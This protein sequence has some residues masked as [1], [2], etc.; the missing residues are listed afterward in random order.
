MRAGATTASRQDAR[1][2]GVRA[3]SIRSP[4]LARGQAA[5]K[6]SSL[7]CSNQ[8]TG[9]KKGAAPST[10]LGQ[11][12]ALSAA[13]VKRELGGRGAQPLAQLVRIRIQGLQGAARVEAESAE[14]VGCRSPPAAAAHPRLAQ[15]TSGRCARG[16]SGVPPKGASAAA[17]TCAW[18]RTALAG[19]RSSRRCNPLEYERIAAAPTCSASV[20][21]ARSYGCDPNRSGC[22]CR[23]AQ[24]RGK[25][26]THVSARAAGAGRRPGNC[27][28]AA[29]AGGMEGGCR[30]W[31]CRT[32]ALAGSAH[33]AHDGADQP[34]LRGRIH[35]APAAVPP[36]VDR[37][38]RASVAP[39]AA[40]ALEAPATLPSGSGGSRWR[41]LFLLA[42]PRAAWLLRRACAVP[43]PCL[44]RRP[45]AAQGLGRRRV[46]CGVPHRRPGRGLDGV[47]KREERGAAPADQAGCRGGRVC[48]HGEP[49]V[50]AGA[51]TLFGAI[52]A[53]SSGP[54]VLRN[55]ARA[56]TLSPAASAFR[57]LAHSAPPA[58]ATG[59]SVL[60]GRQEEASLLPGY[61][62]AAWPAGAQPP[63]GRR[64]PS[65]QP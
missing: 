40:G 56:P 49:A 29:E 19:G 13:H 24:H 9:G 53:L 44:T 58:L 1:Q 2:R 51:R 37:L 60:A 17:P 48:L 8:H 21:L 61:P 33:L 14:C 27:R 25:K 34:A 32:A 42:R 3:G 35:A 18:P 6:L 52:A 5:A 55:T 20:F 57:R 46:G 11:R 36:G 26:Y 54:A 38:P 15:Q 31:C 63:R 28:R 59:S 64:S 7:R 10:H 39:D 41:R 4:E 30:A 62:A 16:R 23:V 43:A 65:G 45:R 22:T 12:L 50:A 47:P